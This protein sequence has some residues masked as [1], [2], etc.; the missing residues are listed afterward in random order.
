MNATQQSFP[1]LTDI[2]EPYEMASLDPT[3]V[4]ST[5]NYLK[6]ANQMNVKREI[7]REEEE[8]LNC[9]DKPV[10]RDAALSSGLSFMKKM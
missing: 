4:R 10:D 8:A 9:P 6:E 3:F 5:K 2:L 1:A 7:K